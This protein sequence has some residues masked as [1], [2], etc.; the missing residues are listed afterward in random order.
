MYLTWQAI[1]PLL[2]V[3]QLTCNTS[4]SHQSESGLPPSSYLAL[5]PS[6]FLPPSHLLQVFAVSPKHFWDIPITLQAR[7][8]RVTLQHPE[9]RPIA[10]HSN[11]H[12]PRLLQGSHAELV[13]VQVVNTGEVPAHVRV[14]ADAGGL[15]PAGALSRGMKLP[16]GKSE[17][18]LLAG[19]P[20]NVGTLYPRYNVIVEGLSAPL[21]FTTYQHCGAPRLLVNHQPLQFRVETPEQMQ[22][23]QSHAQLD[24]SNAGNM[25]LEVTIPGGQ[26]VQVVDGGPARGPLVIAAGSTVRV[27]LAVVHAQRERKGKLWLVTNQYPSAEVLVPWEVKI[28]VARICCMPEAVDMGRVAAGRPH[29][30]TI[31]IRNTHRRQ[32][33][34]LTVDLHPFQQREGVVLSLTP[35]VAVN[36]DKE[37]EHALTFQLKAGE[38]REFV[39]KLEAAEAGV[40]AVSVEAGKG[41]AGPE[42]EAGTVARRFAHTVC[43]YYATVAKGKD[44]KGKKQ[45]RTPPVLACEV[46]V[47]ANVLPSQSIG[48]NTDPAM[49]PTSNGTVMLSMRCIPVQMTCHPAHAEGNTLSAA[50]QCLPAVAAAWLVSPGAASTTAAACLPHLYDQLRQAELKAPAGSKAR[51]V[52]RAAVWLASGQIMP[53]GSASP[54]SS[55]LDWPPGVDSKQLLKLQDIFV[56]K[57][58]NK[59]KLAAAA[60]PL[61]FTCLEFVVHHS[62]L[63]VFKP[64]AALYRPDNGDGTAGLVRRLGADLAGVVREADHARGVRAVA[65]VLARLMEQQP[66]AAAGSAA[67]FASEA[68][69]EQLAA[70][71]RVAELTAL[72]SMKFPLPLLVDAR[73]TVEGVAALLA[74]VLPSS[75]APG[76][77]L[78]SPAMPTLPAVLSMLQGVP[79]AMELSLAAAA[80]LHYSQESA[81]GSLQQ[82]SGHV[83]AAERI[84]GR[85]LPQDV[86]ACANLLCNAGSADAVMGDVLYLLCD[87]NQGAV[88]LLTALEVAEAVE[89]LRAKD[90]QQLEAKEWASMVAMVLKAAAVPSATAT[91][92]KDLLTAHTLPFKQRA[93]AM[94]ALLKEL[95]GCMLL[96]EAVGQ[97]RRCL[98]S[99][100]VCLLMGDGGAGGQL[101]EARLEDCLFRNLPGGMADDRDV[102]LNLL[103]ACKSLSGTSSSS[104]SGQMQEA[105]LSLTSTACLMGGLLRQEGPGQAHA[106]SDA[107]K[108]F[109]ALLQMVEAPVDAPRLTEEL[110]SVLAQLH[111]TPSF[112]SA[113]RPAM[114]QYM[115]SGALPDAFRCLLAIHEACSHSHPSAAGESSSAVTL[116][117]LAQIV[118]ASD[119]QQPPRAGHSSVQAPAEGAPAGAPTAAPPAAG[120]SAAALPASHVPQVLAAVRAL[121]PRLD[122]ACEHIQAFLTECDNP[123]R[124]RDLWASAAVCFD[125]VA[126][127]HSA[128]PQPEGSNASVSEAA[129]GKLQQLRL[130]VDRLRCAAATAAGG[131]AAQEGSRQDGALWLKRAKEEHHLLE[132]VWGL[133]DLGS[134]A[135]GDEQIQRQVAACRQLVG[136]MFGLG[137]PLQSVER[138]ATMGF[139]A[140]AVEAATAGVFVN[141]AEGNGNTAS[142]ATWCQTVFTVIKC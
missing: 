107:V 31:S 55:L 90:R 27:Q 15:Q 29:L 97:L 19:T 71:P 123:H 35:L 116:Q 96:E 9:G 86:L 34:D 81:D 61:L 83:Q 32:P 82:R 16:V 60:S 14:A 77:Q 134:S 103:Q 138:L 124:S 115:R 140:A 17:N 76:T 1:I 2:L 3:S 128:L 102:I 112:Q 39:V 36:K 85:L 11:I 23:L 89:M 98:L 38:T 101:T 95:P 6:H 80:E 106:I 54:G 135:E 41:N 133:Q 10:P 105:L 108:P 130:V 68:P 30:Q 100:E 91:I 50:L 53:D 20:H 121:D 122:A 63:P 64:F 94:L 46:D 57:G 93:R 52:F 113:V 142:G 22:E 110:C 65:S 129:A 5:L 18:V 12:L 28:D 33:A 125:L 111:R 114:L 109:A 75:S 51:A 73:L 74:A 42:T 4:A 127:V 99:D 24:I 136:S 84:L 118:S 119:V 69:V 79:S 44:K 131:M 88:G 126:G 139:M 92:V 120:A 137:A 141:Y 62:C 104:S 7:Q 87:R 58:A 67:I 66:T 49:R 72:I 48:N 21:S 45:H 25:P 47:V 132:A 43:F 78:H 117:R 56:S 70:L 40:S 59:G 37:M 8:P 13:A 26:E